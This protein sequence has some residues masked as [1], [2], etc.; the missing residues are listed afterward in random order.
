MKVAIGYHVQDGA[1][2][3]GNRFAKSLASALDERGD[4]VVYNLRDP[5]I[6]V[7]FL[8]DPRSRSSNISFAA[9][10]CLN[11]LARRPEA[12]VIHRINE[13]DERK[14]TH[15]MNRRLR[16]ANYAADHTVF[17]ASWLR[18]LDLWRHGEWSVVLNGGEETVFRADRNVPWDGRE[19]LK[20]V[21]HHWGANLMKGF[22]IYRDIDRLL[23]T[24]TWKNRLSFTYVG[25]LPRGFSFENS[26]HVAPL[27]G[28]ALAAEL[29]SHHVYVTG[30]RNEPAGMHHIEGA[31]CGLPLVYRNSGALPE[32]CDG[33]GE[34]FDDVTGF[35]GAL[36]R[37]MQRYQEHRRAISGYGHLARRMAAGYLDLIDELYGRRQEIAAARRRW[38]RP[39]L[40]LANQIPW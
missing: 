34:M 3:G 28:D 1:W 21:T 33:Y 19:P 17:I 38:R 16:L 31:L 11:Y 12:V 20:M 2:G 14:G 5:D 13:C 4:T 36:G 37:M 25:N 15:W 10:A 7:L 40:M 39:D 27:D 9:G 26:R 18:D 23:G 24:E 35:H 22:D 32:Y 29:A 6:D 30:S 8:T